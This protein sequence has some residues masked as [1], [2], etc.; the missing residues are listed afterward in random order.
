MSK[1]GLIQ[2]NKKMGIPSYFR[3]IL[4]KYPGVISKH[5]PPQVK[6][7]CFDFNC[8]IYHCYHNL[9]YQKMLPKSLVER[10][11]ELIQEVLKYT[12]HII[13][14]V[15]PRKSV[16]ICIDGVVPMAK[17]HQQRLRRYKGPILKEWENDL[18]KFL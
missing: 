6:A 7:L 11:R 4:Q 14:I 2:T 13:D 1:G 12:K 8:L 15:K 17:M 10:Q 5:P 9:D 3:R 18:K 16:M